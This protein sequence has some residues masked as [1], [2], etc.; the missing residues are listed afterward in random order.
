MLKSYGDPVP[1]FDLRPEGP[2]AIFVRPDLLRIDLSIQVHDL[3]VGRALALLESAVE[4]ATRELVAA[5]PGARLELAG[6]ELRRGT[7]KSV[8]STSELA[9]V[10]CTGQVGVPL[11]PE[12]GYWQRARVVATLHSLLAASAAA[13]TRL[14]PPIHLAH[15]PAVALLADPEPHRGALQ[16]L[17]LGRAHELAA[18]ARALGLG[19]L[20]LR[21]CT[22]PLPVTQHPRTLESVELRLA[23]AG[24]LTA[25]PAPPTPRDLDV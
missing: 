24:T 16:D 10:V 19:A 6:F 14:K 17:W 2:A 13:G 15:S 7:D 20:H 5:V 11:T 9:A 1:R 4:A 21:E 3:E 22:M 23:L 12:Q 8:R 18:H 25:T